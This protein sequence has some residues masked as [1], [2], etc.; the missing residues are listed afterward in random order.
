VKFITVV[1]ES[2]N[3]RNIKVFHFNVK[4]VAVVQLGHQNFVSDST[5]LETLIQ[6]SWPPGG[7]QLLNWILYSSDRHCV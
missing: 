4:L 1:T 7:S 6:L 5:L 3:F 2:N